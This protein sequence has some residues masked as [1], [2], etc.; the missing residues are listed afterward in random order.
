MPGPGPGWRHAGGLPGNVRAAGDLPGDSR[1]LAA[2]PARHLFRRPAR[3][4]ADCPA[5][6]GLRT[7]PGPGPCPRTT[8]GGASTG[9]SITL[10]FAWRGR[11]SQ[12]LAYGIRPCPY[13]GR[14]CRPGAWDGAHP[15]WSLLLAP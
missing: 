7:P 1:T 13:P 9:P 10:A 5:P 12:Y 6:A 8:G 14:T 2:H 4:S 3:E 11:R 15:D